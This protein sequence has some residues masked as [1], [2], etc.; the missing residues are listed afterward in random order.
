MPV[1]RAYVGNGGLSGGNL[2][3]D[4]MIANKI[5]AFVAKVPTIKSG[6]SMKMPKMVDNGQ[7]M[8][9]VIKRAGFNMRQRR[10]AENMA[11]P[12]PIANQIVNG[13]GLAGGKEFHPELAKFIEKIKSRNKA[14]KMDAQQISPLNTETGNGDKLFQANTGM[15]GDGLVG[16][17]FLKDFLS[18]LH[19]DGKFDPTK[20]E[21][22]P[23]SSFI[24][25]EKNAARLPRTLRG[26]KSGCGLRGGEDSS[27]V[28][29]SSVGGAMP[30]LPPLQAS[31]GS[32]RK[33]RAKAGPNDGRK[34]RAAIV[35]KVM[36]EQRLSL[37][38]ASKYVKDH[39][40]Y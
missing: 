32:G 33:R 12:Q 40:L 24:E 5:K 3:N 20:Y 2:A 10:V 30:I 13:N 27:D 36:R 28:S 31:N 4:T 18:T 35:A 39:N 1:A 29:I 26:S 6:G 8:P 16:G 38:A 7:E 37:P 34:V 11:A 25:R 17:A 23:V 9:A 21:V 22:N 14:T 19:K 15:S